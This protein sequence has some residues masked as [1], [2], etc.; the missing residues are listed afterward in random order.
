MVLEKT[1]QQPS[2]QNKTNNGPPSYNIH[3]N[4][5]NMDKDLCVKPETIKIPEDDEHRQYLI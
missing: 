3:K 4:K 2:K 1:R 5:S